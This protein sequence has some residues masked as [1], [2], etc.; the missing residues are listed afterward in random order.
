MKI[1]IIND[2]SYIGSI[3]VSNYRY[4]I[5]NLFTDVKAINNL[6]DLD[7]IEALFIGN[8]HFGN[9]LSV[10]QNSSFIEKCNK[11]NIKVFVHSCEYIHTK[12]FP[13]NINIQKNL[14]K[15]NNLAQRVIDVNDAIILNKKIARCLCSK[16]YKN[17][18]P[19]P[20]TKINKCVFTGTTY[21]HRI[22]LVSK[23]SN[24]I[25]LDVYPKD[26]KSWEEY[27]SLI[28]QYRFVLSPYSNDSNTFHLKFYEALLVGSIPI[29]QI[30]ENT[31]NFY[32][33]EAT[34]DDA[35]YFINGDEIPEKIANCKY[36]RSF[37]K[38]WLEDELAE[39]FVEYGVKPTKI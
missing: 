22:K 33:V 8:D 13:W 36:E 37:N 18:I 19:V 35:I 27:M 39:F 38:P 4:A 31:L 29:H 3:T 7:G 15:F 12:V 28:A 25:D 9:H 20:E 2:S 11:N 14:E 6:N 24:K 30:Y 1:G 17:K 16:F 10:W 5:Q 23:L 26:L 21:D 32:T 34:Y